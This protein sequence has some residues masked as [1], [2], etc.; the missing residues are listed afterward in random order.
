MENY[1]A[2]ELLNALSIVGNMEPDE[3]MYYFRIGKD[4]KVTNSMCGLYYI[5]N[6]YSIGKIVQTA[7]IYKKAK[8]DAQIQAEKQ[9]VKRLADEIGI[10]T[11]YVY[12]KELRG[13]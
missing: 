9:K 5:I 11:L 2:S 4:L 7:G 1:S 8:I 12:V 13:E 6:N 10:H 3:Q